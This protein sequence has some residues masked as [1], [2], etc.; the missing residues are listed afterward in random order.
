MH[1]KVK[2]KGLVSDT[3]MHFVSS[4][5][6]VVLH[7]DLLYP[8]KEH[9]AVYFRGNG[10]SGVLELGRVEVERLLSSARSS[11]QAV[12]QPQR[13]VTEEES[14]QKKRSGRPRKR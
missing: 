5:E 10:V 9:L 12:Q 6:N 1:I 13:F 14:S 11:L 2:R 3:K 4:I 7:E 8:T